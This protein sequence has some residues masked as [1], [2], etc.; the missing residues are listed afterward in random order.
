MTHPITRLT[1]TAFGLAALV[2]TQLDPA[3]AEEPTGY[4]VLAVGINK[5]KHES[6][7]DL[8]GA[9]NDSKE[10]A[11]HFRDQGA[12]EVRTFFDEEATMDKVVDELWRLRREIKKG[13]N[14]A[15]FLSGHGNR[16]GGHFEFVCHDNS[17]SNS[18]DWFSLELVI[19]A[20]IRNGAHVLVM[21]DACHAGQLA[22]RFFLPRVHFVE[23]FGGFVLLGL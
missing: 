12:V 21:I 2:L 22:N 13:E 14:V 15:I 10:V 5:Y 18:F 19:D 17:S 20:M 7:P 3:Y 6:V 4:H 9:V 1:Q 8:R 16:S 23:L 11:A